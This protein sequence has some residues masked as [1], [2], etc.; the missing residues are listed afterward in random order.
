ME[1]KRKIWTRGE[2]SNQ[3]IT[4][5]CEMTASDN[6]NK[7]KG[8]WARVLTIQLWLVLHVYHLCLSI[9]SSP[10]ENLHSNQGTMNALINCHWSQSEIKLAVSSPSKPSEAD[11]AA[12][13]FPWNAVASVQANAGVTHQSMCVALSYNFIWALWHAQLYRTSLFCFNAMCDISICVC[14]L[15]FGQSPVHWFHFT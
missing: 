15:G 3:S 5:P 4:R 14:L 1:N 12:P 6:W 11:A 9:Y 8:S 10:N 7:E 2:F 13:Q